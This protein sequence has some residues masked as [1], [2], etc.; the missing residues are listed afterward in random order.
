MN[1]KWITIVFKNGETCHYSPSEYTDYQYDGK[2]FIVINESQWIGMYNLK[3]IEA[4]PVEK[5]GFY[6]P[7]SQMF[8]AGLYRAKDIIQRIAKEIEKGNE[9]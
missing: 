3:E 5:D 2:F 4:V 9:E 1:N 8:V 6:S 7:G